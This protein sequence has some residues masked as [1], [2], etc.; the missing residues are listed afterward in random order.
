MFTNDVPKMTKP[1]NLHYAYIMNKHAKEIGLAG[2][3]D[4]FLAKRVQDHLLDAFNQT[5]F[6]V[7]GAS[8]Q[9]GLSADS[10]KTL[11]IFSSL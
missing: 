8:R 4:N 5:D 3:I 6:S 1:S 7:K 2:P 11:E 10:L 9:E